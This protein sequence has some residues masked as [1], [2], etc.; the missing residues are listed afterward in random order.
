MH[1]V[2]TGRAVA[3]RDRGCDAVMG[4]KTVQQPPRFALV[5]AQEGACYILLLAQARKKPLKR[6]LPR[7]LIPS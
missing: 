3:G 6:C 1:Q 2:R 7:V 5:L 4:A